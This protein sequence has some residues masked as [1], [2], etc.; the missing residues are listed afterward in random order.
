M[1]G[2]IEV[3]AEGEFMEMMC[4]K[5]CAIHSMN[6]PFNMQHSKLLYHH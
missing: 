4:S 2:R 5:S 1:C 6:S 3:S